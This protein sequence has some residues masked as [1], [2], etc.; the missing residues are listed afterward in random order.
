VV[1]LE[2]WTAID[3]YLTD[4]L[5]PI[6]PVLE[7]T[8]AA[9]AAAGL[10]PHDVSPTQG[11]LLQLLAR[12]SG[13][14][15]ILELGTLAGYSTIWLARALSEDGCLMSLEAD[16][17]HAEL[18]RANIARAGLEDRVRILQGPALDTLPRLVEEGEAF[19]LIFIDADKPNNA[20]YLSHALELSRPGT[21]I[22]ADN[23]IRGG[24]VIDSRSDDPSV[25]GVRRFI[26][27]LAAD[28]RTS[29][30]A[31]QTVGSKGHDGFALALVGTAR[32]SG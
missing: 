23:V 20:E 22:I 31:I 28:P 14:R 9:S 10:P 25:R 26:E 13:A 5:L 3:R 8:L 16:A 15:R 7:Q 19:D 24:A 21:L 4:H 2:Q 29:A 18:A 6:D 30:T 17:K 11:M 1:S 27:M 32:G 12:A